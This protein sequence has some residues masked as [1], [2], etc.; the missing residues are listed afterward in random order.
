M[1]NILF[2]GDRDIIDIID[3]KY[4]FV[5]LDLLKYIRSI[6][7][8]SVNNCLNQVKY[9]LEKKD[10]YNKYERDLIFEQIKDYIERGNIHIL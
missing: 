6:N 4:L 10:N 7:W 3:Q 9:Q 5:F 1:C 2:D 8:I